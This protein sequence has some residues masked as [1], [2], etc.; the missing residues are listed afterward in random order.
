MCFTCLGLTAWGLKV[1]VLRGLQ[2]IRSSPSYD[3][4]ASS[5]G[6]PM[7]AQPKSEG[8][9]VPGHPGCSGRSSKEGTRNIIFP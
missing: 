6:Q 7:K 3:I 8:D 5:R 1:P 2:I 9:L 4:P